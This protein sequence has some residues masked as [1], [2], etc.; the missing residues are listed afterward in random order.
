MT[1]PSCRIS[2]DLPL[3]WYLTVAIPGAEGDVVVKDIESENLELEL[4]AGDKTGG[5]CGFTWGG[6][7]ETELV[8][9][10]VTG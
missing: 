7:A 1:I 5:G 2:A 9:Q 4:E 8:K 10:P 3:S 6:E